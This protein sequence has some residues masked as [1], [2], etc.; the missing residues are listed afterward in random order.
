L[1][2]KGKGKNGESKSTHVRRGKK[3]EDSTDACNLISRLFASGNRQH[4]GKKKRK[5]KE[6]KRSDYEEEEKEGENRRFDIPG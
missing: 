2:F 5:G 6:K 1:K 4:W 3:G